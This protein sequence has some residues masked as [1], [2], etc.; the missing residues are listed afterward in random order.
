[1]VDII[2]LTFTIVLPNDYPFNSFKWIISDIKT[3]TNKLNNFITYYTFKL[4][5][6]NE[7]LIKQWS[8]AHRIINDILIF[9]ITIMNFEE[10]ITLN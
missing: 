10:M 2:D 1:M 3:T 5:C 8:P 4:Q 7:K 6:H 9:I